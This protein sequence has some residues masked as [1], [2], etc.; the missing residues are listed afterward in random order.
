MS[1]MYENEQVSLDANERGTK[2]GGHGSRFDL[3]RYQDVEDYI[4]GKT[5]RC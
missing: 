1:E 2:S 3:N 5:E 4:I